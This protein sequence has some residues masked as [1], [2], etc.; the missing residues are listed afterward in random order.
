MLVV[1]RAAGLTLRT[2]ASARRDSSRGH[3]SSLA[4]HTPRSTQRR[5]ECEAKVW[6][7]A[8]QHVAQRAHNE[9]T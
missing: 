8:R 2:D 6:A 9:I 5:R 7:H 1:Q 4:C 3:D